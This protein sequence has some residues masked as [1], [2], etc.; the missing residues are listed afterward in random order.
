MHASQRSREKLDHY[1]DKQEVEGKVETCSLIVADSR[2][3][4]I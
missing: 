1:V 3:K 2:E 4:E